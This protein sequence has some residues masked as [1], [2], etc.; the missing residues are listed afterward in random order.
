MVPPSVPATPGAPTEVL[1]GAGDG[2]L[3]WQSGNVLH[4]NGEQQKDNIDPYPCPTAWL[5][6]EAVI[7]FTPPHYVQW[8]YVGYNLPTRCH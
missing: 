8:F 5:V 1:A 2:A 7:L 3:S 6:M 4:E